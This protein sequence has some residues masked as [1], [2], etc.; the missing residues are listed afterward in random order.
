MRNEFY[1]IMI[2][3]ELRNIKTINN[4]D[5]QVKFVQITPVS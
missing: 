5:K 3:L 4:N 2:Q 1:E